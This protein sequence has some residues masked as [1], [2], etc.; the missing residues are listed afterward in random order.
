MSGFN[1]AVFKQ[2]MKDIAAARGDLDEASMA[3]AGIYKEAKKKGANN[4]MLKSVASL[5]RLD[6]VKRQDAIRSFFTYCRWAGYLDQTDLFNN[7]VPG[8]PAN[9]GAGSDVPENEDDDEEDA[10]KVNGDETGSEEKVQGPDSDWHGGEGEGAEKVLDKG[11]EIFAQG[12]RA[13]LDGMIAKDN[14]HEDAT[15]KGLWE[16]GRKKGVKAAVKANAAAAEAAA[17]G[18]SVVGAE[19]G[20]TEDVVV[21]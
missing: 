16:R 7:A 14:P 2:T 1:E 3:H 10:E 13:G 17:A 20:P 21:H 5:A 6:E 15:A 19:G 11:G 8:L 12:E 18:P 9:L 4:K